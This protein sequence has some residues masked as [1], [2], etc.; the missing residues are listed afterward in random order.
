LLLELRGIRSARAR[1]LH[2]LRVMTPNDEKILNL[3][4]PLKEIA[5]DIGISPEAL[6]RTL[7]QLQNE[8]ILTRIKR[9][10]IFR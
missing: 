7:T 3:E 2:Y 1:V 5:N 9:R 6:S 4:Q 10:I 8:G